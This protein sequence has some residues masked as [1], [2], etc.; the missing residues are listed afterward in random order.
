MHSSNSFMRKAYSLSNTL[1]LLPV[2]RPRRRVHN[3]LSRAARRRSTKSWDPDSSFEA[4]TLAIPKQYKHKLLSKT[5]CD[6]DV[7]QVDKNQYQNQDTC[8]SFIF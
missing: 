4:F 2:K 5:I 7:W 3:Y 1:K 6:T 8:N